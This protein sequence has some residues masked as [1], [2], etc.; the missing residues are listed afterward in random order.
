MDKEKYAHMI[1]NTMIE[2]LG[3]EFTE[4]GDTMKATMPVDARTHQPA[5]L[6]HGGASVALIESLGSFGSALRVDISKYNVVGIEVNANHI[7]G[8][9]SGK[10]TGVATI[11][12]EGKRTHIWEAKVYTDDQQLVSTGRLTVMVVEKK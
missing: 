10:V 12:H 4:L 7:K 8:V 9:T 6:L 11:V 2:H 5:G 1:K 3:M